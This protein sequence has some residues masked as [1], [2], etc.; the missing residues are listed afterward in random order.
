MNERISLSCCDTKMDGFSLENSDNEPPPV[1][2]EEE[3]PPVSSCEDE[4]PPQGL[5]TYQENVEFLKQYFNASDEDWNDWHWQVKN[6][7]TKLD[8]LSEIMDL[9]P[10][11]RLSSTG[12]LPFGITPY[13]ASLVLSSNNIRKCMVPTISETIVSAE[14]ETDPLSEQEQSPI[15]GIV[16]R[17]PD[18]CLFLVTDFCSANCRYC[19]R[20]RMVGQNNL[21]KGIRK[22]MW[23]NA[24]KW[25]ANHPEIRDVLVSGGDPLTLSDENIE[26]IL[27]GLREIPHVEVIRIGTKVPAVLPQRITKNLVRMLK[28]YHP[29]YMSLHF[30]HPEELTEETVKACSMLAD[31]GIPL[32]S[33]TVLLKDI[34]DDVEI[35]KPLMT[36]LMKARVKPYYIYQ[37]DLIPGSRHF[38]TPVSKGLE[39]IKGL[40]GH[41][42]G[43]A[44]PSYIIDAPHGG[45]KI[46]M[47]PEYYQ[48]R[49]ENG[50]YLKNY[51][52]K[53]IFYPEPKTIFE[54]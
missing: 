27:K 42:S 41:I 50:I 19:T 53:P 25:I 49:D 38:R 8:K 22:I 4:E 15:M 54:D 47:L 12:N 7:I 3:P 6:R 20:S 17:Y 31:A 10:L 48:G 35:M 5:K 36:G 16:H 23:Q 28:K 32:G 9:S 39:I 24:I 33:Q 21:K 46:P 14:E 34:N 13:Y 29:L 2:N 51:E 43:Y 44:V 26:F 11:E 37:C 30:T 40:R 1:S 45:G 52:G 18:R